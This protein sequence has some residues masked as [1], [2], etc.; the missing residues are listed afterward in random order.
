MLVYLEPYA[1]STSEMVT[2]ILQYIMDRIEIPPIEA[3]AFGGIFIDTKNFT[4]KLG[5]VPLKLPYLRRKGANTVTSRQLFQ[6]DMSTFIAKA[7]A[8]KGAQYLEATL[9][10]RS[11]LPMSRFHPYCSPGRR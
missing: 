6:S 10:F 2:E 1:S 9:L 7:E 4:F 3:D 5:F 8:V 11:A